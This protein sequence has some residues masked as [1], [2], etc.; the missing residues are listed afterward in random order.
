MVVDEI[1]CIAGK[2]KIE[3]GLDTLEEANLRIHARGDFT[4]PNLLFGGASAWGESLTEG[5]HLG[6]IT[7]NFMSEEEG[8]LFVI[9]IDDCLYGISLKW[10]AK[11]EWVEIVQ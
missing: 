8:Q 2:N 7:D 9:V 4:C 10:I 5:D 6:A 3:L 1:K 11:Q